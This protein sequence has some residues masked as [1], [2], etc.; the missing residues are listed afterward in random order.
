MKF[1]KS[2]S[3]LL[4]IAILFASTTHAAKDRRVDLEILRITPVVHKSVIEYRT[5]EID[6]RESTVSLKGN[7]RVRGETVEEDVWVEEFGLREFQLNTYSIMTKNFPDDVKAAA[8]RIC[9]IQASWRADMILETASNRLVTMDLEE[10]SLSQFPDTLEILL[11]AQFVGSGRE[12]STVRKR[13]DCPRSS[14]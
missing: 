6:G 2:A 7:I 13:Y 8:N 5:F 12:P 11:R 1:L 4:T 10:L 3:S 9:R 14:R